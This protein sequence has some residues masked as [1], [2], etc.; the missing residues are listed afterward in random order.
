M[1]SKS[2]TGLADIPRAAFASGYRQA[3]SSKLAMM[4]NTGASR[5][6]RPY[7]TQSDGDQ[8]LAISTNTVVSDV[9]LTALGSVAAEAALHAILRGV[10]RASGTGRLA[11][12]GLRTCGWR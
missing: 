12:G 6:V 11:V 7:H 3:R 4:A 2:S 5:A 8:V 1:V 10:L 9:S